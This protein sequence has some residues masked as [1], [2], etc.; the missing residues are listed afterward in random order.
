MMP[1]PRA[2]TALSLAAVL[3]Q[4]AAALAWSP[5]PE[6]EQPERSAR[7]SD[8]LETLSN[9]PPVSEWRAYGNHRYLWNGWTLHANGVRTTRSQQRGLLTLFRWRDADD[10]AV[11]CRL[12]LWQWHTGIDVPEP[13]PRRQPDRAWN[14][15]EGPKAEMV[16]EMCANAVG[17]G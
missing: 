10:I 17:G 12:L 2:F 11:D 1:G 8:L 15:P 13:L 9:R 6:S 5:R 16:A 7:E 3:L 14:E 4:P